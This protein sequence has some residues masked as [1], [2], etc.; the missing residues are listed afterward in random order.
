MGYEIVVHE[1]AAEELEAFRAYDRRLIVEAI[2]KQL[3]DQP[4]VPTRRRKCLL[5]LTPQFEHVPPVW[6]LRVGSFRVLTKPT[7]RTSGDE[8][9]VKVV[10][11]QCF[12]QSGN[13]SGTNPVGPR[14]AARKS[15]KQG[16]KSSHRGIAAGQRG[17]KI[18]IS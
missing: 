8:A 6:E 5:A 1:K 2:E 9:N 7:E 16:A 11:L 10:V 14:R 17:I 15:R 18:S 12:D 3:S 13:R 4:T